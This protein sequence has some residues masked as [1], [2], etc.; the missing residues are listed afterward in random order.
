MDLWFSYGPL[1]ISE[2]SETGFQRRPSGYRSVAE[3]EIYPPIAG[4]F[5]KV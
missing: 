5:I 1:K 3:A 4:R 2:H